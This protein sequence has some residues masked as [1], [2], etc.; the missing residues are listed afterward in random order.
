[1]KRRLLGCLFEL[2]ETFALGLAAVLLIQLFVAEPYKVPPASMEDTLSSGQFVL[3]DKLS[4]RF[5]SYHRGD[6]V[7]FNP[8]S[9]WGSNPSGKPLVKRVIAV[10]GDIVDIRDGSV[11]VNNTKLQE[12]YV[13]KG[14]TTLPS[15]PSQHAWT[16]MPDQL[17]LMGDY[18]SISVDSRKYGAIDKSAVIGRA[19]VRYWPLDKFEIM[20]SK[21][22]PPAPSPTPSPTP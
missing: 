9:T 21:K 17:F 4:T 16:L 7:V 20:G 15:D 1:M 6:I 12:D 8:P 3:V 10:G 2:A 14:D 22:Q 13:H 11:F 5:D 18:R 19:F